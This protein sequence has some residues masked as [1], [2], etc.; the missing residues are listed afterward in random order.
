MRSFH[1][2]NPATKESVMRFTADSALQA[3][4]M[5]EGK[6]GDKLGGFVLFETN[7]TPVMRWNV[8]R[9]VELGEKL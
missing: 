3:I 7:E 5:M 6:F 2:Y 8:F 9:D 4:G 1:L